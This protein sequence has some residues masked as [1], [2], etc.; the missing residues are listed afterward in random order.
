MIDGKTHPPMAMTVRFNKPDY[1]HDLGQ[2]GM[3][4]FFLMTNTEWLRPG[5]DYVDENG[6]KQ[7][8][9]SGMEAFIHN[10]EVLLKE[11]PDAYI[12]VRIGLHPPVDW[13]EENPD[14]L[15][16]YQDG[17]HEPSILMSEV[18]KDDVPGMYVFASEKW[19]HDARE[20]LKEF[21]D[22][23][24]TLWFKEAALPSGIR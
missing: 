23:V 18:H 20:A 15:I 11:V 3:K 1:I 24:D 10:A 19:Q 5:K 22:K 12:I 16:T 17:S 13:M 4:V 14:E 8:E 6:E 2:S 21:C 7:H 9:P